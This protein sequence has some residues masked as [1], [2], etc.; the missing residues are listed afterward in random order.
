MSE[1]VRFGLGLS[2]AGSGTNEGVGGVTLSLKGAGRFGLSLDLLATG[3]GGDG[4]LKGEGVDVFA[5]LGDG[6]EIPPF[7]TKYV[8]GGVRRPVS[9]RMVGR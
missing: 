6:D 1:S 9:L 3:G 8:G 2:T 7:A 4:K 5:M